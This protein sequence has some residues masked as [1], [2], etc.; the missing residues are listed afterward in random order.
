MANLDDWSLEREKHYRIQKDVCQTAWNFM[1]AETEQP[2]RFHEY[3]GK[4]VSALYLLRRFEREVQD[5]EKVTND[6]PR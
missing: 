3:Y 1:R 5:L 2:E 6:E 4:L